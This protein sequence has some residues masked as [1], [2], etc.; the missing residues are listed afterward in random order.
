MFAGDTAL[1]EKITSG[2][3]ST[4]DLDRDLYDLN[5]VWTMQIDIYLDD[6][7]RDLSINR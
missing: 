4:V 1:F 2:I 3:G 5:R 6:L 7:D